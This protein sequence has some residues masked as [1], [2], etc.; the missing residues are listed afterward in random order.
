LDCSIYFETLNIIPNA[1][2]ENINEV[3]P[4]E[5]IGIGNPATGIKCTETA[6]FAKA[7]NTNIVP[8]PIAKIAPN[9]LGLSVTNRTHLK[10]SKTNNPN[11]ID[12]PKM[13]YSSMIML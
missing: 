5:I 12:A 3:P 8:K 2:H 6:I 7:C 13:P 11:I 9:A 4:I 1:T 10:N